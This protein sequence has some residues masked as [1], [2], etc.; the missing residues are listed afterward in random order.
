MYKAFNESIAL[1]RGP[2]CSL[3]SMGLFWLFGDERWR[4]PS[5]FSRRNQP[6]QNDGVKDGPAVTKVV[7]VKKKIRPSLVN[8]ANR[9]KA[10]TQSLH[11]NQQ[12]N[13]DEI[14]KIFGARETTHSSE[15]EAYKQVV[16]A[17]KH[18]MLMGLT[19]C[20]LCVFLVA[21]TFFSLAVSSYLLMQL[22]HLLAWL[23][24][25]LGWLLDGLAWLLDTL[26]PTF[27]TMAKY[28]YYLGALSA[29]CLY[30][31]RH[32]EKEHV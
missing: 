19:I 17:R 25:G 10:L 12:R 13:Y 14:R 2:G 20:T 18:M 24:R 1:T 30:V 3:E 28:L 4:I 31:F 5:P 26:W 27:Y 11:Q 22:L 16:D 23:L 32:M 9:R 21:L 6:R 15:K 7:A 29:Y 8:S